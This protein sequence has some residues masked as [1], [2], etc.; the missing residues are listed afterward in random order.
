M[1]YYCYKMFSPGLICRGYQFKEGVNECD[2]ATCVKEGFHAAENPLD[3]LRYYPSFDANECWLCYA[4]GEIHEKGDD[5]KLSCTRLEILRRLEKW[6]FVFEACRYI[7][8]HPWSEYNRYVQE[9]VGTTS[10][11]G[12]AIVVGQDPQCKC[13]AD[14]DV[15]ALIVKRRHGNAEKMVFLYGEE[16]KKGATYRAW[17]GDEDEQE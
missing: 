15:V 16:T 5:S 13:L 2:H 8:D 4:D 14:G 11:Q 12:F 10:G 7:I 6:E 17:G 9:D 3:C 1:G